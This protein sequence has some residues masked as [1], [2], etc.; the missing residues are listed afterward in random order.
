MIVNVPWIGMFGCGVDHG[1]QDK[2]NGD[3]CEHDHVN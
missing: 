3:K 1:T 2:F